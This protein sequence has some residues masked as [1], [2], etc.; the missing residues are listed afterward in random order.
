MNKSKLLVVA[1][2]D[3]ETIFFGGLI[4]KTPADFH[5][6]CVT[7]GNADGRGQERKKEFESACEALGSDSY[8]VWDFPDI[9]EK[10]LDIKKLSKK[11][12]GL[13]EF[14]EVYTHNPLG[15]YGHPHHQDVS[16][17]VYSIFIGNSIYS[18]AYNDFPDMAVALSEESF[19]NKSLILTQIYGKETERFLNILPVTWSEGFCLVDQAEADSIYQFLCGE[20]DDLK[21]NHFKSI[22]AFIRTTLKNQERLF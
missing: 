17:A 20:S 10:R 15:E 7:D 21:L 19:K 18:P 14:Q 6:V 5:I 22:E 8:E 13:G 2:P 3:D 12:K 16:H 9:Y 4:Q 11:L 1:H